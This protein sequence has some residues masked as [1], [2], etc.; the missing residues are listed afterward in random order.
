MTILKKKWSAFWIWTEFGQN[1]DYKLT[2][3]LWDVVNLNWTHI[4]RGNQL[5]EQE[6][7]G[8]NSYTT[9]THT[10]KTAGHTCCEGWCSPA[11]RPLCRTLCC[12][13]WH[14]ACA[15]TPP[16]PWVALAIETISRMT[17]R[18]GMSGNKC[19][20]TMLA[21]EILSVS[22]LYNKGRYPQKQLNRDLM[23]EHKGR[24]INWK[25]W[26]LSGQI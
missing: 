8:L 22:F 7:M 12:R 24:F 9:H 17:G 19:Q 21:T 26:W 11:W 14:P 18:L 23:S 10:V 4:I 5:N 16:Q 20:A 13:W 15:Q 1:R 6:M 3:M 25:H 2:E